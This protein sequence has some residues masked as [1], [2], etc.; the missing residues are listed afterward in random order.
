[1]W[2]LNVGTTIPLVIYYN[3]NRKVGANINTSC[4]NNNYP[5]NIPCCDDNGKLGASSGKVDVELVHLL[6]SPVVMVMV[7]LA[8]ATA[9]RVDVEVLFVVLSF[10]NMDDVH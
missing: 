4:Y 8:K 3:G 10:L 1:M 6:A 9:T 7:K 5:I 2:S